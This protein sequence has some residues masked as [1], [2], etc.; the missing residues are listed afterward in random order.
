MSKEMAEVCDKE[1][2]DLLAKRAIAEVTDDSAGFVCSFFCIKKKQAG[3]FRPIVNLKPLN[4]FIRY[5][6]FKM[7]NLESVRFLVRKGDWLAKVDLKDA[8]FTV[9]VKKEHRKYLRFRWGKRVFEFNCM[10]FGLAP[11]PRVFT[12]ILKTVMA[13]LR[14]KGIRL[15]IY[16]DDILVLNESK[17]GLVADVNTVL[18]LLQSL[19]FLINWEKSII[20]PTQVIEY[21]GLIV[22]SNDPSFSLPC[23]K[24]AAVRKMCETALSEG[25]VSLRTIASIQGNFAWAIPAIPFAQAHY[26]SLQRFYISNAQR[27]DFNL[28]AKVRLSPSAALD[29]EWWVANIEKANGKMFFPREPDLEIFSDA[30]LTGWGAVCNGVTTRGPWTVQ[31]MNKHI[32]ELELL[33]AF[34][35]IQTFSAKTSNIAIRIFLDNSTAVS[36]VNKCGGTKSAALTN[37]AKAISAWCEEKSISVEAVHLAGELN[38]I[39]DRESRAEADTSDWRLDAT[40]FS[41]IS[42]IWEMDVDLF[43]SSWNSQLPRFIAW[44]PQPGA[45]AA[46]AFSVRWENIYGYAF[47]PFSLIFR[48]IEKIRREKASIILICP[49]WTGQPWFPVLL[50]HACDIPRLLRPSPEL[51]TSARGEPHPL[52]QSGALSLAAWKLSGDPTTCK[53]FR[54]RL[55]NFSWPE[56]AATPIPHMNQPGAVGSIGVW[57]G[58]SIPCVAI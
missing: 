33:G 28:E 5:Q 24:A 9:G 26:R 31:D 42:E 51:L 21:L 38:V 36:Y 23:A 53:A 57:N 50:E 19:G 52:I 48:C 41:R 39:A 40:I 10:A 13:F 27:V 16:L 45:F 29:L 49:V 46:N 20:A 43:A 7:E 30:S 25:K 17:E 47:P 2:K 3:Q 18:E 1:V 56:A 54:S 58:I 11:A 15:V 12:K 22:D 6:H 4:K 8:Y 35:A 32:N 34:F 55:S 14:R 37:T 44:G